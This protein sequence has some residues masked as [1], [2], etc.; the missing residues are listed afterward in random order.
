MT[1]N[2]LLQLLD[3]A[4]ALHQTAR[5]LYTLVESLMPSDENGGTAWEAHCRP[6]KQRIKEHNGWME[7]RTADSD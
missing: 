3:R 5:E 4:D 7:K 1:P 2:K 6:M